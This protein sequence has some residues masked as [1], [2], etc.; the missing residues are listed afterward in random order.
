MQIEDQARPCAGTALGAAGAP[1]SSRPR[2]SAANQEIDQPEGVHVSL[3]AHAG[4]PVTE[5]YAPSTTVRAGGAGDST[6]LLRAQ[7]L[8]RLKLS[9]AADYPDVRRAA[10]M[11]I[12]DRLI[13]EHFIELDPDRTW[14]NVF[15]GGSGSALTYNGWQHA[16]APLASYTLT[17]MQL[18]NFD[19]DFGEDPASLDANTGI[20]TQ[21]REASRFDQ[22]NEVRLLS[23][24]LKASIRDNDFYGSYHTRLASYYARNAQALA[25]VAEANVLGYAQA[26]RQAAGGLSE[27]A[28][29]MLA[30]AAG[31]PD[32]AVDAQGT[33]A[34]VFDIDSWPSRD[35][36]W[37]CA[38]DGHVVL[39]MPGSARPVR[40]Y[41]DLAGMRTDVARMTRSA[42]GRDELARHF[43]IT[44][45]RDG[46]T[47]QGIDR[48][49]LD[50][51][52]GGYDER[53]AWTPSLVGERLFANQVVRM[54]EA[55]L[56]D[57]RHLVRANADISRQELVQAF[58]AFNSVLGNP[59]T[60]VA[61]LGLNLLEQKRA[62]LVQDRDT[63]VAGAWK[64]GVGLALSLMVA[65][66][67]DAP[68]PIPASAAEA[69][70]VEDMPA[71]T[72]ATG[73][74]T[75]ALADSAAVAEMPG[76]STQVAPLASA[77][78]N[79]LD[80]LQHQNMRFLYRAVS[81][82]TASSLDPAAFGFANSGWFEVPPML[83][84]PVVVTSSTKAGAVLFGRGC[85]PEGFAVYQIDAEGLPAVSLEENVRLNA[86]ALSR[87]LG[88]V[89]GAV[90]HWKENGT[91]VVN[92]G[93][94]AM[95]Y[96]EVHL[97]N[98]ALGPE[99]IR[100]LP[101]E[102]LDSIVSGYVTP[103]ELSS[104][105]SWWNAD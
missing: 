39:I 76:S 57:V 95:G 38:S 101:D 68:D 100:R 102:E 18:R 42:A 23:S 2:R 72:G 103:G 8:E 77:S 49:L 31:Y 21:G 1:L 91:A 36:S 60:Q 25:T 4:P 10:A 70:G 104:G 86:P 51:A 59:L 3:G 83:E 54:R 79:S 48:W 7:Q 29:A 16:R 80:M 87:H 69:V 78:R 24:A 33:R 45:R 85:W 75:Q 40:E 32:P 74:D 67:A 65:G 20:Y 73:T 35:M 56:D 30:E 84:G 66:L 82:H 93:N 58:G 14:F 12:R 46:M 94:G 105:D 37:L 97:S 61:E 55:A 15:Q 47:Y 92:V 71:D 52:A 41:A 27:Q 28:M 22:R 99:R 5:V 88:L 98:A 63:A 64:A 81:A 17:D 26:T 19:A 96:D 6:A 50:I 53:I 44:N 89:E 13:Q 9:L 43:S 62:S 11:A 34:Y 90:D